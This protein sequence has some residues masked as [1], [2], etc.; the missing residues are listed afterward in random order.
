MRTFTLTE[1]R[2]FSG[3]L[4][5]VLIE[6]AKEIVGADIAEQVERVAI[7]L[8]SRLNHCNLGL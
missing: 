7:Q 4:S 5:T 1:V 8:Y 6:S 3:A 2:I